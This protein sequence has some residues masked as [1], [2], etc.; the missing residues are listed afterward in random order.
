MK[1]SQD[2]DGQ[3]MMHHLSGS[4]AANDGTHIDQFLHQMLPNTLPAVIIDLKR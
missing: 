3:L 1:V 4:T 2:K